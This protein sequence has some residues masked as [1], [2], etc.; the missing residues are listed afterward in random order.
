MRVVISVIWGLFAAVVYGAFV[1]FE[2]I[3]PKFGSRTVEIRSV[4][5]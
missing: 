5:A 1:P 4:A 3:K 2:A